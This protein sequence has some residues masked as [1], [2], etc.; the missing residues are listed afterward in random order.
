MQ[1]LRVFGCCWALAIMTTIT[2]VFLAACR[3]MHNLEPSI[4]KAQKSIKDRDI[5]G[6]Q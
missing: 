6:K 3:Y 2:T 1:P 4:A 5:F